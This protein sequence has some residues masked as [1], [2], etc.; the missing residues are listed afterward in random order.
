MKTITK[1]QS[2]TSIGLI[3][4]FKDSL[5]NT[6]IKE[7]LKGKG[8]NCGD[9]I[10]SHSVLVNDTDLFK[11]KRKLPSNYCLVDDFDTQIEN[12]DIKKICK[13]DKTE[14]EDCE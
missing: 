14:T 8:F 10:N 11:I 7:F 2:Q 9:N 3:K 5:S 4:E 13:S 6:Q 1:H 12:Y